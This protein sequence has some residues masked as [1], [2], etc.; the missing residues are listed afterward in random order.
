MNA[1]P[2]RFADIRL[3][4]PIDFD[5]EV[6]S[7]GPMDQ[8][9]CEMVR[10]WS[11]AAV[12]SLVSLQGPQENFAPDQIAGRVMARHLDGSS[13]A[14]VEVVMHARDVCAKAVVRVA[15]G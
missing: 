1:I 9:L 2:L 3:G 5:G 6:P 4:Q 8:R 11:G 7:E 15:L 13:M 12:A 10:R 14:D